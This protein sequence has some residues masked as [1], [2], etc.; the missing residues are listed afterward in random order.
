M[1]KLRLSVI[2]WTMV[3]LCF[4]FSSISQAKEKRDEREKHPISILKAELDRDG[5]DSNTTCVKRTCVAWVK[6]ISRHE[7]KNIKVNLKIKY[8]TRTLQ[9]LTET[10]ETLEPGKRVFVNFKWDD[11]DM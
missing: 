10:I 2:L 9:D 6:N 11:Y 3:A 4:C 5:F 7:V 8:K 1:R